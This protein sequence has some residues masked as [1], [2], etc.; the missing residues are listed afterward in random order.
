[1]PSNSLRHT[2]EAALAAADDEPVALQHSA[3]PTEAESVRVNESPA[4]EG[5]AT[6]D[7]TNSGT[8]PSS[9][10]I[11]RTSPP[12]GEGPILSKDSHQTKKKTQPKENV[13]LCIIQRADGQWVRLVCPKC[14][15]E[16]FLSAHGFISHCRIAHKIKLR[17]TNEAAIVCGHPISVG[18]IGSV[19]A[20][21]CPPNH[22]TRGDPGQPYLSLPNEAA[23][24]PIHS[25]DE[26][27]DS[28]IC[29]D[30]GSQGDT[31]VRHAE[32]ISTPREKFAIKTHK[33]AVT[34]GQP[35]QIDE[36]G[37]FQT[38]EEPVIPT[39][40]ANTGSRRDS[41]PQPAM[42]SSGLKRNY[43]VSVEIPAPKRSS[44][45]P[46]PWPKPLG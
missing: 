31:E 9:K 39:I 8:T 19:E 11:L 43:A 17:T 34:S 30:I 33:A 42:L 26:P 4:V 5:S 21:S 6:R 27:D 38:T 46:T 16:N 22:P 25:D 29:V 1:M 44:L 41:E 36:V 10:P 12:A 3:F 32:S 15:K 45:G 14:H 2:I 28:T 18:D 13:G 37:D 23:N 24:V 20:T 40:R 35:V 7:S